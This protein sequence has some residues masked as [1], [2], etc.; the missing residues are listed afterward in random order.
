MKAK[1]LLN[2]YTLGVA[3]LFAAALFWVL[4]PRALW[5]LR[6]ESEGQVLAAHD[7]PWLFDMRAGQQWSGVVHIA[8]TGSSE[9]HIRVIPDDCLDGAFL[10]GQVLSLDGVGNRCDYGSGFPLVLPPSD[11]E[12]EL[13]LMGH[14]GGGPGGLHVL[15]MDAGWSRSV[16]AICFLGALLSLVFAFLRTRQW[17]ARLTA[18][19]LGALALR[20]WYWSFT[21]WNERTHDVTG[22][23]D[24]VAALL[25]TWLP[26][27]PDA[28]WQC[29]QPPLYYYPGAV[30]QAIVDKLAWGLPSHWELQLLSFLAGLGFL[31]AGI[32]TLRRLLPAG[33]IL[34]MAA[35]VFAF[36]PGAIVH[37]P[38]VGNDPFVYLFSAL[39]L[40]SFAIWQ[41]EGRSPRAA[42]LAAVYGGLALASKTSGIV[43]LAMVG[44]VLAVVLVQERFRDR[45]TWIALIGASVASLVAILLALGGPI[46]R[47]VA[48]TSK[49]LFVANAGGLD[50]T[51]RVDANP[52]NFLWFD[53]KS[54]MTFPYTSPWDDLAGRVWFLNYFGKT[55]LFGEFH[56][57]GTPVGL[58]LASL[59]S[60]C[61]LVLLVLALRACLRVIRSDLPW[62]LYI[63]LS[64]VALALMR[65]SY[66][67]SCSNDARYILP[68]ILPF[69]YLVGRG[70][71]Y[72][73]ES[74]VLRALA[75][76]GVAMF[77]IASA[78]L[79]IAMGLQ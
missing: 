20:L 50:S 4:A 59:I 21:P 30:L 13:V 22:H 79:F 19:A 77:P 12:R 25:K 61:A 2:F 52:G 49:Y 46:S 43:A 57:L 37:A 60:I 76:S 8:P 18:T 45:K 53:L 67:F 40:R 39:A 74:K 55:S 6:F 72:P 10:D 48:G 26:P 47:F 68:I 23:A 51:I 69:S 78:A 32:S 14:N 1:R 70:L 34:G 17:S 3:L 56:L 27:A 73:I 28:C 7:V 54:W 24:Y 44:L 11:K 65:Y 42:I 29:Y 63:G 75:W 41:T 58:W 35:L 66:P 62:L 33:P 31:L 15:A 64:L 9:A 5:G 36:W 38:R 16:A 71:S